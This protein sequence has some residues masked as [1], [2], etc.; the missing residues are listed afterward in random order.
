[1]KLLSTRIVGPS[2][3]VNGHSFPLHSYKSVLAQDADMG[4]LKPNSRGKGAIL[5]VTAFAVAN[6]AA[7]MGIFLMATV[8]LAALY[9]PAIPESM[10]V[11]I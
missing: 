7:I 9:V 3:K 2:S 11:V 1:M 5:A 8:R 6:I 4:D 10:F